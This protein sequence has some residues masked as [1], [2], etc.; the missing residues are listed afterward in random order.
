[1]KGKYFARR[2][3]GGIACFV[4]SA[5][6]LGAVV[7]LLWNAILPSLFN[8]PVITYWQA[9]GIFVL[10]RLLFRGFGMGKCGSSCHDRRGD[11]KQR[12]EEKL[13]TMTPEER[14]KYR[15]RWGAKCGCWG[16]SKKVEAN[17]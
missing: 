17:E 11:W 15:E 10:I 1:M 12:F 5:L 8:G 16:G 9:V 7:M 2:A 13:S 3:F 14:E 4:V 6:V